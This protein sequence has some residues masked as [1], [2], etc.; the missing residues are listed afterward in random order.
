MQ[1][2]EN[3]ELI[4]GIQ[5]KLFDMNIENKVKKN[6]NVILNFRSIGFFVIFTQH[7]FRRAQMYI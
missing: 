6:K 3:R 7:H 1:K 4:R 2:M 5:G